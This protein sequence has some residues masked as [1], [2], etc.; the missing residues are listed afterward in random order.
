MNLGIINCLRM[1]MDPKLYVADNLMVK[2]RGG[3]GAR[4]FREWLIQL[5]VTCENIVAVTCM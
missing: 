5:F 1:R 2:N 3:G 4:R